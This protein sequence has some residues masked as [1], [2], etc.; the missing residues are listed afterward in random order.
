M[1]LIT[2]GLLNIFLSMATN[3]HAQIRYNTLDKCFRNPGRNYTLENLLE[4]CNQAIFEFDP[5]A[6]GIKKRQ[7]YEDIRY[8]ESEQGW[9][10]ELE[11]G[12]KIGRK[13]VYRYIDTN[14]SISNQKLNEDDANQLKAAIFSLSRMQNSWADEL[15]VRLR[16]N[17]KMADDP[18]KIIEFEENEFLKGKEYVSELYNAILYKKVLQ[19]TYQSFKATEPQIF[20]L[21]PYYLKQYNNRWFLFGQ[22]ERYTSL[23]NLA[24]DRMVRIVEVNKTYIDTSINFKE[25]FDDVVG[26]TVPETEIQKVILKVQQTSVDYINTKALHGSQK[27]KERNEEYAIIELDVIPNYELLSRILSFGETIEILAPQEL[28]QQIQTRIDTMKSAYKI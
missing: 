5:K 7:L 21:H 19:I 2:F 13:R 8:M 11:E 15:S 18:R 26:V 4:T 1:K 25:Y 6:E 23:S 22:D 20:E 17:F 14:F 12:L 24:L 3:K 16:E 27:M 10:I 9:R 28:R